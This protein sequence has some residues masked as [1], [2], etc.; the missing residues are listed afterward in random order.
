MRTQDM[1]IATAPS[2]GAVMAS[3]LALLPALTAP[4]SAAPPSK[5]NMSLLRPPGAS[6]ITVRSAR[7]RSRG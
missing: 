6:E 7:R 1:G 5:P 3:V 4:S 2:V